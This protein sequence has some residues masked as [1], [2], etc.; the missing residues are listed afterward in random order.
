MRVLVTRPEPDASRTAERL[1]ALGHEPVVEPLQVIQPLPVGAVL[2]AFDAS[3]ATSANAIRNASGIII[4]ELGNLPCFCVGLQTAR[5]AEKAGFADIR[6]GPG[7][8]RG[9]VDTMA[10]ALPAR[11]RIAYLCGRERKPDLDIGLV[12]AGFMVSAIETYAT[13]ALEPAES[14]AGE[15]ID[16]VMVYSA[17]AARRLAAA[18]PGLAP[19]ARFICISADAAAALPEEWRK[20]A[21]VAARPDESAMFAALGGL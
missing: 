14:F 6:S 4:A 15:G 11:A 3:A 10:A 19:V 1:S 9:L 16:V 13:V 8:A 17:G 12:A 20:R 2:G 18:A 21:I 5:A 7:A